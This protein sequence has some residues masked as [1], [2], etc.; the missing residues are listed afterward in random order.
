MKP[1]LYIQTIALMLINM[2]ESRSSETDINNNAMM[3][4]GSLGT[5]IASYE[6]LKV[7]SGVCKR[8]VNFTS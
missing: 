2:I 5:G 3:L 6:G 4:K 1:D 7:N 8:A